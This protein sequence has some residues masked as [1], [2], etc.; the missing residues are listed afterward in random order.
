LS[1]KKS[2]QNKNNSQLQKKTSNNE[3]DIPLEVA[4]VIKDLPKEKQKTLISAL[5]ISKHHSGPLPDGN[6]IR[7]YNEV[8]PD[9]GDRLMNTV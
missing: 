8:I 7:I 3:E 2:D 5:A 6:S 1:R 4:E 9:G